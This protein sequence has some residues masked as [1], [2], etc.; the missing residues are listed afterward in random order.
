M[1]TVE[2][3]LHGHLV[4]Y[5]VLLQ[6]RLEGHSHRL[7]PGPESI[8]WQVVD[9]QF[10]GDREDVGRNGVIGKLASAGSSYKQVVVRESS[11]LNANAIVADISA[12]KPIHRESDVVGSDQ[13]IES[14][15]LCVCIQGGNGHLEARYIQRA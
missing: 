9:V 15:R 5:W 12:G 2:T 1:A 11:D 7:A 13:E 14:H 4:A 8:I 10:G 3:T 6:V